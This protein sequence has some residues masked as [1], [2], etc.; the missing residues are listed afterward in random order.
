MGQVIEL[1]PQSIMVGEPVSDVIDRLAGT[2][3]RA[4]TARNE[5]YD[6]AAAAIKPVAGKD[7][8][9]TIAWLQPQHD[10]EERTRAF[11]VMRAQG[12]VIEHGTF[13]LSRRRG[14]GR[15]RRSP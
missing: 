5:M 11:Q 8:G 12:D 3:D 14:P 7:G 15:R 6:R 13:R 4:A 2:V 9:R 1:A 10:P